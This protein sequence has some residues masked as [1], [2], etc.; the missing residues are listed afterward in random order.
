MSEGGLRARKKAETRSR[1]AESA[2][3]LFAARGYDD[4]TVLDV[5]HASK[6]SEKTVFNYFPTKESLA[7]DRDAEE[8]ARLIG[9]LRDRPTGVSP[10]RAIR[11]DALALVCSIGSIPPDQVR[12]TIGALAALNP[13]VRR[14]CLEMIDRHAEALAVELISEITGRTSEVLRARIRAYA[15]QIARIYMVI[16]DESGRRL[17]RGT[18][19]HAVVRQL[20]PVVVALLDDLECVA[21]PCR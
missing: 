11:D 12:G 4:V 13:G 7:L 17:A 8:I 20:R 15:A 5:A 6:V 18:E 10:A 19:P 2:A 9:L 14:S 16:I 21:P 1:I 3:R